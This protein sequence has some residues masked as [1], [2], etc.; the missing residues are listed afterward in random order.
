L[1]GGFSPV[2]LAW[3]FPSTNKYFSR[4]SWL[5]VLFIATVILPFI[6]LMAV[7]YFGP[8]VGRC[9]NGESDT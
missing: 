3:W 5:I 6:A 1:E 8:P 7:A 4:P 9:G 2:P